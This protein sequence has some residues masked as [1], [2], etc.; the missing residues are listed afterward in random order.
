M[1]NPNYLHISRKH[2]LNTDI[3]A[4]LRPAKRVRLESLLENLSLH[5]DP[6][7]HHTQALKINPLLDQA[8]TQT[9]KRRATDLNS[10]I[11]EKMAEAYK[12]RILQG[13]AISRYIHPFA[14]VI[15]HF[16]RWLRRLFNNFVRKYNERAK[17]LRYIKPFKSFAGII[18]LTNDPSVAFTY[19]DLL[20]IVLDENAIEAQRL[21]HKRD[22]NLDSKKLREITD[23]EELRRESSYRYWD[24]VSYVTSDIDMEDFGGASPTK[25]SFVI[26]GTGED[27]DMIVDVDNSGYLV[28]ANYGNYYGTGSS[29][30]YTEI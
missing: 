17:G 28:K 21:R 27:N 14:I 20:N 22:K 7:P 15:R 8:E 26:Q 12:D 19:T 1:S 4:S 5:N 11:L 10:I 2:R 16:Q 29:S 30:S 3:D 23:E 24:R 18:A 6:S 9:K 25:E 13:L